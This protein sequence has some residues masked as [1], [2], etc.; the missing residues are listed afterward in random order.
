MRMQPII[1]VYDIMGY[2]AG[3]KGGD[4]DNSRNAI[5]QLMRGKDNINKNVR[6]FGNAYAEFDIIEGLTAKTSVG[7]DY[8]N[9]NVR[10]FTI[11]E[12]EH[13][14]SAVTNSLTTTNSYDYNLTW[15]NTLTYTKTF[16][17]IHNLTVLAGTEAIKAYGETFSATR[18]RFAVDDLANSEANLQST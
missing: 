18:Q 3:T 6:V 11:R 16:G 14:E 1:P 10:A 13:S 17:G 9:F 4:L 8:N 5:G 12:L 7:I 15:Y 2:P